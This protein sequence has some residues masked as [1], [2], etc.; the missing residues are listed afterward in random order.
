MFITQI[1][2]VEV[3]AD[4]AELPTNFN[5]KSSAKE[6][7]FASIKEAANVAIEALSIILKIQANN[8]P[9]KPNSADCKHGCS[10]T[11]TFCCVCD[12]VIKE[13]NQAYSADHRC[14]VLKFKL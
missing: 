8:P 3:D 12:R 10:C 13:D 7:P 1:R 5:L 9:M 4:G 2:L 6:S 11:D 14:T